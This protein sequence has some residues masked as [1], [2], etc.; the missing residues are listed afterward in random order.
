MQ[1]LYGNKLEAETVDIS[2]LS[3]Y[4]IGYIFTP[5]GEVI[6]V[7]ETDDHSSVFSDYYSGYL[8]LNQPVVMEVYKASK[9]LCDLN[10]SLFI[11]IR[12]NVATKTINN[13]MNTLFVPNDIENI[14]EE[15]KQAIICLLEQ[16]H[17]R[18][19]VTNIYTFDDQFYMEEDFLKKIKTS[20]Q[21]N[22]NPQ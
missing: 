8:E 11:G 17:S 10:H 15:E 14:P 20:Y 7:P 18:S 9:M 5:T 16:K 2:E 3:P 1:T 19:I 13:S 4:A 21:K 12:L 22:N 6:E